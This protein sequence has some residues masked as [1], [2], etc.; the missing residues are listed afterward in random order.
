MFNRTIVKIHLFHFFFTIN[1]QIKSQ[2]RKR[3]IE[4]FV[5]KNKTPEQNGKM[6]K[7]TFT[8]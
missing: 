3:E 7:E 1:E 4:E 2:A 6:K 8:E 5:L